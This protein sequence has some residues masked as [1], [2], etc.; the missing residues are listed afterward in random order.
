[1]RA[2]AIDSSHAVL[3]TFLFA[4]TP[5]QLGQ[6]ITFGPPFANFIRCVFTFSGPSKAVRAAFEAAD[7]TVSTILGTLPAT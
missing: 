7:A 3:D 4:A 1:L 6:G 5:S 2:D